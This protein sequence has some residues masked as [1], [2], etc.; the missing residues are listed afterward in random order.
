MTFNNLYSILFENTKTR[1]YSCLMLDL[2]FLQKDFEKLQEQLCP[3][4]IY[5]EDGYGCEQEAHISVLYGI[6]ESHANN[7]IPKLDLKPIKFKLTGLSLFENERYDVLKFDIK[8]KGL[9]DLNK[10]ITDNFSYT[11]D[12]P[13]YISHATI[14]YMEPNTGRHYLKM[15]SNLIGKE[16]VSNRYIFSDP[17]GNKVFITV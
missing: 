12:F 13:K 10:K 3:C 11:S 9:N 8:S 16:F 6:H 17:N 14:A 4:D 1:N 15:K 7:I 5:D 2:S